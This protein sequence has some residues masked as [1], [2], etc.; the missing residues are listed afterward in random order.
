MVVCGL[1]L[2]AAM[3]AAGFFFGPV[4]SERGAAT[5]SWSFGGGCVV[6]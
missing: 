6:R 3:A 5:G 4:L 2:V 1:G